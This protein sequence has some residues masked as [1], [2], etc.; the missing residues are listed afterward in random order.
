M[1]N[2]HSCY[3]NNEVDKVWFRTIYKE[4]NVKK[5]ILLVE[6]ED[7]LREISKDYFEDADYHVIE[8]KNGKEALELFESVEV[9]LIVLDIMMPTLDG[10]TVCKRIRE[11]SLVP[12]VILTARSDEEDT[13]FGFELG[14]SD[15][16]TKPYSPQILLARVRRL[17]Q[18]D[19]I[20]DEL[21]I[22][23]SHQLEVNLQSHIV[24]V[25]KIETPLTHT[26]FEIL[27]YLM[28]NKNIV[29]TREQLIMK[30]WGYDFGGDDRT[31]NTHIRNLRN[32]LGESASQIKTIVRSGYKFE[33]RP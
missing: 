24:K 26:E 17:L 9:D 5:T 3:S 8:A 7:I 32:K 20:E 27:A 1:D 19:E 29:V 31:V 22:L 16:V 21:E 11:K 6:D 28:S 23:R 33:D 30:I 25:N 10:W 12:I 2:F 4:K 15:Y 14:T 13:L 18:S